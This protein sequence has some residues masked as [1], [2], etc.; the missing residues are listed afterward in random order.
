M[1]SAQ[2]SPPPHEAARRVARNIASPFAAQLAVRALTTVSLAAGE[3][4][5]FV[6]EEEIELLH[7]GLPDLAGLS[8]PAQDQVPAE[9]AE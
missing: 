8:L 3:T 4:V 1:T 2:L 5:R 6:A 7:F 9:A